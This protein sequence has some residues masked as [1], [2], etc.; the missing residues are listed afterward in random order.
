MLWTPTLTSSRLR[1][2][3]AIFTVYK[4]FE[5]WCSFAVSILGHSHEICV[6]F[7][8]HTA[9][10]KIIFSKCNTFY[11]RSGSTHKPSIRFNKSDRHTC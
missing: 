9:N 11:A 1:S 7:G 10:N 4:V 3:R 5:H 6:V 2:G 8:E